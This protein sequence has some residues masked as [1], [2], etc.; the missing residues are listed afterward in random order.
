MRD[1]SDEFVEG[2]GG[3]SGDAAGGSGGDPGFIEPEAMTGSGDRLPGGGASTGG[4]SGES[5]ERGDGVGGGGSEAGGGRE[6]GAA[7]DEDAPASTTIGTLELE[8]TDGGSASDEAEA[9][10]FL[11]APVVLDAP[12]SAD[13]DTSEA[14]DAQRPETSRV[15]EEPSSADLETTTAS[16]PADGADLGIDG[17]RAETD[18]EGVVGTP[19]RDSPESSML[20]AEVVPEDRHQTGIE[21]ASADGGVVR[22]DE[23][24]ADSGAAVHSDRRRGSRP[25]A[26]PE[27]GGDGIVE[28]VEAGSGPGS[29]PGSGERSVETGASSESV[30]LRDRLSVPEVD[31]A[32]IETSLD[33]RDHR[34]DEAPRDDPA[35]LLRGAWEQIDADPN[36]P[37]FAP[38]GYE[39]NIVAIDP[40]EGT[41]EV[42]RV[43]RG[44]IVVSGAFRAEL[45][46]EGTLLLSADDRLPHR[47]PREAIRLGGAV[48]VEPPIEPVDLDRRWSFADGVFEI[49]GRR[50]ARIDRDAFERV[51]RGATTSPPREQ[52]ALDGGTA[53]VADVGNDSDGVA[54]PAASVDFFGTS[55]V[56]RHIC[57]V[58][59]ISGS[60][61]GP[62]LAA[63]LDELA[64][65]IRALP[66]DRSFYVLFFSGGK[67]VLE[68]RWQRA[69]SGR[70]R[71]FTSRFVDIEAQGGTEPRQAIEHAFTKL[72]PVPDEIHFMTDGQIPTDT[73][74]L[75]LDLNGGRIRTVV[76]TYA[77]GDSSGGAVLERIAAEHGGQ[78]RFVPDRP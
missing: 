67:L 45:L 10:D 14:P 62:R 46:P 55:I 49:E 77:F 32:P 31:L 71:A 68:D 54:D 26:A 76:H 64:R 60:M 9:D 12:S 63:A 73:P 39:R 72:V 53:P 65:S 74:R 33:R 34:S 18:L 15:D 70:K 40:R 61:A 47:F 11:D 29:G 69:T 58:V 36:G 52:A 56:G 7:G 5:T 23:S 22:S 1:R 19:G 57:Y 41:L 50:F 78:Y 13:G 48:V 30:P 28:G 8:T 38:G 44:G 59:D 20:D 17:V 27:R 37:D 4:G 75:L 25:S 6:G 43:Y 2:D 3:T 66:P 35:W 24:N 51:T 16:N 42:Y 21:D